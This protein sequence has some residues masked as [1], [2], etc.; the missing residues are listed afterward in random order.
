MLSSICGSPPSPRTMASSL[1]KLLPLLLLALAATL[2]AA[3]GSSDSSKTVPPGAVALVGDKSIE[4]ADLDRLLAQTK[5]NYEAQK[6]DFPEV[7][8][9]QYETLKSTLLKGL[10]QQAQWEQAGAAMGVRISEKE[11]DTRLDALK[12]QYFKGDEDKFK[13][14]LDKE[15]LTVEQVREQLRARL[16]SDK[17]YSA[18]IKKVKVTDAEIKAYYDNHKAQ[19]AQPASREVRHILVKKRALADELY[20]KLRNGADFAKLA[21]KYTQD[22]SSKASG[23]LYTAYKGK[24]VAPF[25]KF[26]FAAKKGDLS[27]PI[28]TEFGWH[29][30]EVLSE[31][32]PP[33]P[34]PLAE[35]KDTI[36]STLLQQQQN[37]ALKAWVKDAQSKY[38]ITYAPGYAPAS[39]S[40]TESGTSTG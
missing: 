17:I 23:G 33:A 9:P 29:V 22:E 37:Q 3:C 28:K 40:T 24:S 18:V 8:T 14:E 38:E 12:Q 35:A 2:V 15:G 26:V 31:V 25:D 34:Q 16:L 19:Y 20:A 21:R 13:A 10:V 7:G 39:T 30:I 5:T 4:K 27:K 6:Q 32:K 1:R 11:L 36:S